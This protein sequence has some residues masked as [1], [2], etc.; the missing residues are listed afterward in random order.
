MPSD[1]LILFRY[2]K[3]MGSY[4]RALEERGIPYEITGSDA[5]SDSEY[6]EELIE[7][8]EV[9]EMSLTPGRVE[10]V[11]L[12]NL[13]KAKGLEAPVVFLAN[14]VGSKYFE[15][16]KHVVRLEEGGPRGY[17]LFKKREWFTDTVLS[18]P[19]DWEERK[20]EEKLYQAA[21]EERLMYVVATRAKNMLVVSNI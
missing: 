8:K 3:N 15:P 21:E 18:Q 13:H 14:P 17:F 4:A 9:E 2:K 11:R 6:M 20:K 7:V 12:M 16:D 19:I 5:F 10:A 1:F